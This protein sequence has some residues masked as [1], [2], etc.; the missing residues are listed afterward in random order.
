MYYGKE[1]SQITPEETFDA[2]FDFANDFRATSSDTVASAT[3]TL[4]VIDTD[5][6]ATADSNP[7]GQLSGSASYEVSDVSGRQ[8]IAIQRIATCV[9]GNRYLIKCLAT[10]ASGM[11]LD[12]HSHFWCRAAA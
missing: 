10:M 5:D 11:V 1:L 7:A 3:F 12:A 6:G 8:T 9:V 2:W 4:S